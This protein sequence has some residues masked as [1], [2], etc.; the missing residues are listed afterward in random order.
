MYAAHRGAP[1]TR[2]AAGRRRRH[3]ASV[4]PLLE[5]GRRLV[6]AHRGASAEHPE[7]TLESFRVALEQGAHALELDVRATADGEAVVIHDATLDRTTDLSGLVR[8]RRLA[9]LRRADAG[10]RFAPERDGP[11]RAS[12]VRV[13]TLAEVLAAFPDVSILI[14]VKEPAVAEPAR[15]AILEAGAASRVV[16]ASA[17]HA[18]LERFREPPFLR[19]ASGADIA[20]LYFPTMLGVPPASLDAVAYSVPLRWRGLTIPTRRVVAAARR[21]GRPV[22]VWTVDDPFTAVDL[23]RRGV[24]GIVT[25]RPGRIVEALTTRGPGTGDRS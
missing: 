18:A 15:R 5:L 11:W 24:A 22:H 6:I 1:P 21:A 14:E 8:E 2:L 12:G 23:W 20:R 13:P 3:L 25:N 9:E 4:N 16:L 17:D 19:G 7:N 10:A